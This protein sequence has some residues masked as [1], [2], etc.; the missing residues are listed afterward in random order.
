MGRMPE[1]PALHPFDP[2]AFVRALPGTP[3]VYRMF[4]AEGALLYVGKAGNLRNRVGSYFAKPQLE[5]RIAA[6]VAQIARIETTVTRTAAEALLLEAQLIKTLRPRYNIVL[7]DDKSYPFIHLTAAPARTLSAAEADA[8]AGRPDPADW[9]RMNFHRGARSAPGRYFGPFPSATAVRETLDLVQKLFLVR[10]CGDSFFR[11]RSRP[12]LQYQIRRCT[13]PCVGLVTPAEYLANVRH[14]EMLLEGGASAVM[15]ELVAEME[16]ASQALEFERAAVLRDRIAAVKRV[17]AR[18]YV[19]G[20]SVDMDVIACAIEGGVAGV[21]VL[22]FR[23]G[24]NLGS[25]S[26]FPRLGGTT[27]PGEVLG[28]FL[29]QYYLERPVPPE[30]ITSH[31]PADCVELAE[32]LSSQAGRA[33]AVKFRVRADRARFLDLA[34]RNAEAS[35]ASRLASRQTL[36]ARFE[37]LRD[38]LDLDRVP[39]RIECFD[40]SHTMGEATVA[41]CVVFGPEGPEKSHYRR[42]NIRGVAAGDDYAAMRQA[43]QRRFRRNAVVEAA[44]EPAEGVPA[45]GGS[46]AAAAPLPDV[47]LIDGGKGQ[48][49]QAIDVLA[50]LGIQGVVVVG[51]AKGEARRSGDETLILGGNDRTLWP[52]PGSPASH[53]VQAVRDEAHRFAITG[54]RGRREKTREKSTLE[55][56]PGVGPRRRSALLRHFGG[57][58]GISGAGVEEL[59]Q[60][61]GISRALAERIYDTLHG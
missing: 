49:Q 40:V 42:Y 29:P 46:G 41:A 7:R 9:P 2:R 23:G 56:I 39:A 58:R 34:R 5:P 31:E 60:V 48:V 35:L 6:M 61:P 43:L 19:Q 44:A 8:E 16:R 22:F 37:A 15:D 51:V 53:L 55:E 18:H 3:G 20:A 25:R 38:L 4:D 26:F 54:H 1:T 52:G 47:L 17:Q 57:L 27:D 36:Q 50:G 21:S 11:N 24:S 28:S 59:M 33:V 13:A 14:A 30:V 45:S 12:C 10:N 32:A